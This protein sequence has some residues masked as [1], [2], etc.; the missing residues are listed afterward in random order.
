MGL[1]YRTGLAQRPLTLRLNISNITDK[2]Y[3]MGNMIGDP[4]MV[5]FSATM[6]F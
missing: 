5:S 3:F 1:R 6:Q 2:R 4:R